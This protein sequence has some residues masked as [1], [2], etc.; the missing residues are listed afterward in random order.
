MH[1]CRDAMPNGGTLTI[2]AT[3]HVIREGELCPQE[4]S[5]PGLWLKLEVA[6]TGSGIAPSQATPLGAVL[7]QRK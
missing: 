4:G 7:S 6:D 2:T 5:H 1:Q 3:N